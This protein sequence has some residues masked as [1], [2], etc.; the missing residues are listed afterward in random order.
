MQPADVRPC[1]YTWWPV[2]FLAHRNLTLGAAGTFATTI[3][4]LVIVI[5][6]I[7]NRNN[8]ELCEDNKVGGEKETNMMVIIIIRSYGL[9]LRLWVWEIGETKNFYPRKDWLNKGTTCYSWDL[10][11]MRPATFLNKSGRLFEVMRKA[12]MTWSTSSSRRKK[13]GLYTLKVQAYRLSRLWFI[14]LEVVNNRSRA[15]SHVS[16]R[17]HTYILYSFF[18]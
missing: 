3:L 16:F 12:C 14:E 10:G 7:P 2:L 5:W 4:F 6:A 15:L 18:I 17:Y 8:D 13:V 1:N 11:G 9:L